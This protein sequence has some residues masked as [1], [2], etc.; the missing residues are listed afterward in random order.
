[1]EYQI[2][3]KKEASREMFIEINIH[4]MIN[5]FNRYD[6]NKWFNI[7]ILNTLSSIVS[8]IVKN[9]YVENW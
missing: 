9:L 6:I 1:M 7:S 4:V 5:S 3:A 2:I 8:Q